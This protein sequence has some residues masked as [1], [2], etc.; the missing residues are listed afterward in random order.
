M[1]QDELGELTALLDTVKKNPVEY[2]NALVSH[3]IRQASKS[4]YTDGAMRAYIEGVL[5]PEYDLTH[6]AINAIKADIKKFRDDAKAAAKE[7]KN[8]VIHEQAETDTDT[9]FLP[10]NHEMP[11]GF[12]YENEKLCRTQQLKM[13][14]F[15]KTTVCEGHISIITM[16]VAIDSDE[17]SYK[18]R[19][20]ANGDEYIERVI[21]KESVSTR[22]D[23]LKM[24]GHGLSFTE[25]TVND[26][27]E[28]IFEYYL[29]NKPHIK[30]HIVAKYNGW[31]EINGVGLAYVAGDTAYHK[32]GEL[33][34]KRV[35]SEISNATTR[36]GT[37]EGWCEAIKPVAHLEPFRFKLYTAMASVLIQPLGRENYILHD[38]ASSGNLK[39]TLARFALTAMGEHRAL[40][41]DAGETTVKGVM[42]YLR[43]VPDGCVL[44]DET[45][46]KDAEWL[47]SFIYAVGNKGG[48]V[49]S[50]A[51]VELNRSETLY[52]TTMTTGES[53]ILQTYSREGEDARVI[54]VQ[55][56]IEAGFKGVDEVEEGISANYGH[57]IGRFVEYYHRHEAEIKKK[58]EEIIGT[59]A[60]KM[61][62]DLRKAK[63]YALLATSGMIVDDLLEDVIHHDVNAVDLTH[64]LLK[65]SRISEHHIPEVERALEAMKS[66][67]IANQPK[68]E[69]IAS[70][71][72]S[73]G[74]SRAYEHVAYEDEYCYYMF[75]E[76]FDNIITELKY[77]RGMVE[78]AW[79]KMGIVP[80]GQ[81]GKRTR[82]MQKRVNGHWMICIDKKKMEII[83][84]G[85]I[86]RE[87]DPKDELDGLND[88]RGYKGM[89]LKI[90]REY[91][92][93][94][95][96][97][98]AESVLRTI[99]MKRCA[100][101]IEMYAEAIHELKMEGEIMEP[102]KNKM[103]VI[104]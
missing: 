74:K 33:T 49:R 36:K 98:M 9:S 26:V 58:H 12:F 60:G 76:Q 64:A 34:I 97:S 77:V 27:M 5:K 18:L 50:T 3:C 71:G 13:G 99:A 66:W 96:K 70:I 6:T 62:R 46:D 93:I 87:N 69:D 85:D 94:G 65:S 21:S 2:H 37:F 80:L 25:L 56:D 59:Y 16:G 10:V 75:K 90:L 89:I 92:K 20:L 95:E 91:Q 35:D 78:D 72:G 32:N 23:L 44:V 48:G 83:I 1:S 39:T 31:K 73:K 17:G 67:L 63:Q 86:Q 19:Y 7:N 43:E 81:D 11:N 104:S 82:K 28:Y 47:K 57:L 41:A 42:Q 84:N 29:L 8:N 45:T 52:H 40:M 53:P 4:K 100:I 54:M 55:S 102:T 101:D 38:N 79:I 15:K 68:I 51:N 88:I 14:E 30:T 22:R 61:G 24:I 103:C